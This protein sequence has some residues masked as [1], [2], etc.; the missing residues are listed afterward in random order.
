MQNGETVSVHK[1]MPSP[2]PLNGFKLNLLFKSTLVVVK[3]IFDPYLLS[4]T[5]T[6]PEVN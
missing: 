6:L 3:C 2:K 5:P 1:V 4:V